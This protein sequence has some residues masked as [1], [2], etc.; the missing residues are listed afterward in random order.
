MKRRFER[1]TGSHCWTLQELL[2]PQHLEFFDRDWREIESKSVRSHEIS[3]ITGIEHKILESGGLS[4]VHSETVRIAENMSWASNRHATRT[5]DI[6][7]SFMGLF[8]VNMPL[9]YGEGRKA[10]LR[11]QQEIARSAQ[12]PSFLYWGLDQE[13][14]HNVFAKSP[15]DLAT[16][17]INEGL[18]QYEALQ[19]QIFGLNNMGVQTE[20]ELIRFLFEHVYG[21]HI[22][23]IGSSGRSVLLIRKCP[24]TKD[25]YHLIGVINVYADTLEFSRSKRKLTLLYNNAYCYC[26]DCVAV[27]SFESMAKTKP[28][29]VIVNI[30]SSATIKLDIAASTFFIK[31]SADLAQLSQENSADL[32][33]QFFFHESEILRKK[34]QLSSELIYWIDFCFDFEWH[35]C[36]LLRRGSYT[37]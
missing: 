26:H 6:A 30:E 3:K 31:S 19:R 22:V 37:V 29:A 15:A 27:M 16:S 18:Q 25:Y 8:D 24:K 20:T 21:I 14:C 17:T 9:L 5:E 1:V 4:W 12:E 28:H 32:Q 23:T 35:A 36:F 11:L 2:T 10:F 13:I 33:C 7:Y 34:W